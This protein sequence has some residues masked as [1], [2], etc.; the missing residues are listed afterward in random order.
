[1]QKKIINSLSFKV[2]LISFIVQFFA[3]MLICLVLYSRTPEML[4]SPKEELEDIVERLDDLTPGQATGLIDDFIRRTGVDIVIY[5][6]DGHG[7]MLYSEPADIIGTLTLKTRA[8]VDAAYDKLPENSGDLGSFMF[9]LKNDTNEYIL[10]YFYYKDKENLVPRALAN[11]YPLMILVVVTVSLI[12][13]MIYTVLFALPVKKLS[14]ASHAMAG[15]D[16]TV[17]CDDRRKDEIGDLARDLNRMSSALDAKICELENEINRVRELESQKEMFFA[18]A[19]HE[20]KTPVTILEGHIRG[21]LEGVGPY[22]D[23]DEY[24]SKSLRSVKRIESLIN[25]ILTASK[26]QLAEDIAF[27]SVDMGE[28]LKLKLEESKDLFTIRDIKLSEDI[29]ADLFFNGNKELTA[30]AAGAFISNAVLY[31][32]EGADISVSSHKEGHDI[33]TVIRN[34]DS[35]I[36]EEDLPHLFEAFYR[37]DRSRSSRDGGSGLGLYLARLIITKQGGECSL[38]NGGKDVVAKISLP[39]T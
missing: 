5:D 14:R 28:V 21:M 20:L 29:D 4:Y 10:S 19:S 27:S 13:S 9:S 8:E 12:S 39:S 22:A 35:H 17:R 26:M 34:T 36:N 32:H 33:V 30:L 38:S 11:S 2:F 37:P 24:L 1:M 18:A 7:L 15:M 3:G 16:F 25:E 23:H 31:S 6:Y